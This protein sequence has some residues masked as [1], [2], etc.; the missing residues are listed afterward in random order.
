LDGS[1]R[2]LFRADLSIGDYTSKSIAY[3]VISASRYRRVSLECCTVVAE[4][5]EKRLAFGAF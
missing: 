2:A 1:P 5:D 3:V 4:A